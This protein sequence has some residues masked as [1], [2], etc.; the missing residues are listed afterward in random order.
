MAYGSQNGGPLLPIILTPVT[1]STPSGSNVPVTVGST[2]LTFS[3]V[4]TAGTTTVAPTDPATINTVPGGFSVSNTIAYEISTTAT[5]SGPVTLAFK[6]P[7]PISQTDF[8]NLRIYHNENGTL[9]DVTATNPPPDYSTLTIYGTTT[10]FSP[11]YLVR[12]G[13]HVQPLFDTSKP[14]QAGNTIPVRVQLLDQQNQNI[15]SNTTALT[16]RAV[17]QLVKGADG[18]VKASGNA[19]PGGAFRYDGAAYIFN[20]STKGL[21]PGSYVFSFYVGNERGYFYTVPFTLK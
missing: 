18:K 14:Q 19:N 8:N 13:P 17:T 1:A 3:N 21:A 4:A 5:F 11:F 16:A 12:G 10:S 9:V 7:G 15:G 2:T 6:V 20:L